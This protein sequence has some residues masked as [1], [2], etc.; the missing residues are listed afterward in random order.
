MI[1]GGFKDL[2]YHWIQYKNLIAVV[3]YRKHQAEHNFE[4]VYKMLVLWERMSHVREL[5]HDSPV[6]NHF[7]MGKT[8]Q[9]AFEFFLL[10]LHETGRKELD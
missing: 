7:G 5:L 6:A 8:Y 4:T 1:N 3:L 9:S 10:L 2:Y